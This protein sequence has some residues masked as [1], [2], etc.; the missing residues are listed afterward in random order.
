[1]DLMWWGV[2]IAGCLLLAACIA[3]ALL[4]PR[5]DRADLLRPLA[6]T[7]RLTGLPEY[8]RAARRHTIEAVTVVALLLLAFVAAVLA[9][10]RPTGLPAPTRAA[11]AEQPE[12]IMVC[13]GAPSEDPAVNATLRYFASA[14]REFG[15][16]RIGLTSP[17]RRLIPITRDYQYAAGRF[18]SYAQPQRLVS[19]VTYTDYAATVEDLLAVCVTGFPG[20]D[21]AAPVRRSMIYVGPAALGSGRPLFTAQQ[22]RDMA[23]A[24]G[25]QVN[26]IAESTGLPAELAR[27]TGGRIAADPGEIRRHPPAAQA[28]AGGASVPSAETPEL[29]LIVALAA[30]VTMLAWPWLVRR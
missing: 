15:T 25:V 12:D 26:V 3:A 29:L 7:G 8:A 1:M 6:N 17:D 16:E 24:A 23:N 11:A 30:V 28:S 4:S 10:A 2:P 22:V 20:F 27:Q 19:S 9:V 5:R 13:A 18:A 14:A 21:S